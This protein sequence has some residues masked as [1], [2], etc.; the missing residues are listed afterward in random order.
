MEAR[1]RSVR[2]CSQAVGLQTRGIARAGARMDMGRGEG[3]E[4]RIDGSERMWL[5]GLRE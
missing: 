4:A 2:C 3:H 5:Q 1:D